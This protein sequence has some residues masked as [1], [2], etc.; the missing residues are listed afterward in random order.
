[1]TVSPVAD[2]EGVIEELDSERE[3]W[4]DASSQILVYKPNATAPGTIDPGTG[5]PMGDFVGC[6]GLKV[7]F[8][9][10]GS[11]AAPAQDISIQGLILRDT[12]YTYLDAHGL[13]SGNAYVCSQLMRGSSD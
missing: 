7:L 13:P 2:I 9:I 3:W 4:F 10:S 5:L 6:T 11:Q 1:M 12:T 8:N